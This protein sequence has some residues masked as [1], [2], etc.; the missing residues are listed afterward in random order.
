MWGEYENIPSFV[1]IDTGYDMFG[2]VIINVMHIGVWLIGWD[3]LTAHLLI[4]CFEDNLYYVLIYLLFV[5]C[6]LSVVGGCIVFAI[7]G[8]VLRM[9]AWQKEF[10]KKKN[11]D[12]Y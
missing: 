8:K 5:L 4:S 9:Q 11:W 10:K 2:K 3:D 7:V 12:F 1:F 6:M